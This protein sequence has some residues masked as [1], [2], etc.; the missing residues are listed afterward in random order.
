LREA[1][2]EPLLR[3]LA[4][5]HRNYWVKVA[6]QSR[7]LLSEVLLERLAEDFSGLEHQLK[8]CEGLAAPY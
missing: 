5:A 6:P 7:I 3:E 1:G 2:Y 8:P 4:R